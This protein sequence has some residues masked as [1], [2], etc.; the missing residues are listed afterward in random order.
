MTGSAQASKSPAQ[1]DNGASIHAK[2]ADPASMRRTTS[3]PESVASQ[4]STALALA[5]L[6][7]LTWM[8][9]GRATPTG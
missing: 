6:A 9:V 8:S 5:G 2:S 1:R 4:P 7:R 3:A